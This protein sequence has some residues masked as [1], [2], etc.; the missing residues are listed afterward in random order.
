VAFLKNSSETSASRKGLMKPIIKTYVP[1]I[2]IGLLLACLDFLPEAQ[3][4]VGIRF[5]RTLLEA[6]TPASAPR[7]LR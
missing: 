4:L 6:I 3:A 1:F 5:L 2:A 7:R